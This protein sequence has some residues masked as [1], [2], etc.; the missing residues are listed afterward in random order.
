[1]YCLLSV[2]QIKGKCFQLWRHHKAMKIFFK[3]MKNIKTCN[4]GFLKNFE[5]KT[6]RRDYTLSM[7]RMFQHNILPH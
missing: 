1:M 4:I 3:A 5:D 6:Y 7:L 2:N